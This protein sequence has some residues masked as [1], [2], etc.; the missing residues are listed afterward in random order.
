MLSDKIDKNEVN[1]AI[2]NLYCLGYF[3]EIYI[4]VTNKKIRIKVSE[5]PYINQIYIKGNKKIK[6]N[7][8]IQK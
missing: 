7:K 3:S 5:N 6:T 1:K 8:N 2:K 4:A